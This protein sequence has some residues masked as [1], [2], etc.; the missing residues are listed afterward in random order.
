MTACHCPET[1]E[2]TGPVFDAVV[3]RCCG[4]PLELTCAGACGAEHTRLSFAEAAARLRSPAMDLATHVKRGTGA[5][6]NYAPK[7]CA[8]CHQPFQP[9][10]P[11]SVV[12]ER[13][14]ALKSTQKPEVSPV[15]IGAGSGRSEGV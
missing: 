3:C 4:Q 13:C 1:P 8:L 5:P 2:I 6:R 9:T 10:G 14:K 12:C 11:R 15:D 7:A